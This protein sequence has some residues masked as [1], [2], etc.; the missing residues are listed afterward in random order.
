MTARTPYPI[1]GRITNNSGTAVSG[2]TV[3]VTYRGS[4]LSVLS[5]SSGDYTVDL[6]NLP[7]GIDYANGVSFLVNAYSSNQFYSSLQTVNVSDG[8]LQL[9]IQLLAVT[10]ANM[11]VLVQKTIWNIL[12]ADTMVRYWIPAENIIDQ[13]PTK[14]LQGQGFP[15]IIVHSPTIAEEVLTLG[16]TRKMQAKINIVV[17]IYDRKQCNVR[18][19]ADAVRNALATN[20][21]TT[22]GAFLFWSRLMNES[23]GHNYVGEEDTY[24]VWNM[25]Q[26]YEFRW[27]G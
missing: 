20:Q 2:A 21:T 12:N 14:L 10:K 22:K 3:N 19:L 4:P 15:Y 18:Q 26:V 5:N 7:S 16:P 6:A 24:P 23:L 11:H 27:N 13:I 8:F 25:R 9:N 17:E 1:S